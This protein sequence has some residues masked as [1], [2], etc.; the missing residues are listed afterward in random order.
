M[1]YQ[2]MRQGLANLESMIDTALKALDQAQA[3]DQ[4]ERTKRVGDEDAEHAA[5]KQRLEH[6]YAR[7]TV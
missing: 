1:V 2:G 3:L 7:E 5:K 6:E 4:Q